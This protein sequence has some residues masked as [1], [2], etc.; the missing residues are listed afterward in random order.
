MIDIT[1]FTPL[2]LNE[3]NVEQIF[4]DCLTE[5]EQNGLRAFPLADI[6]CWEGISEQFLALN[7]IEVKSRRPWAG[8]Y[9]DPERYKAHWRQ[10]VYMLGQLQPISGSGTVTERDFQILADGSRWT[11][12]QEAVMQLITL[13]GAEETGVIGPMRVCGDI[14]QGIA[15]LIQCLQRCENETQEQKKKT[16]HNYLLLFEAIQTALRKQPASAGVLRRIEPTMAP[17]DL[18]FEGW[19]AKYLEYLRTDALPGPYED[20]P[21][22]CPPSWWSGDSRMAQQYLEMGQA[23]EAKEELKSDAR[24]IEYYLKSNFYFGEEAAGHLDRMILC[25]EDQADALRAAGDRDIQSEDREIRSKGFTELEA[26]AWLGDL[27]AAYFLGREY[28]QQGRADD[29]LKWYEYAAEAFYEDA[30]LRLGKYYLYIDP[31]LEKAKMWL[32]TAVLSDYGGEAARHMFYLQHLG[33][34]AS[35]MSVDDRTVAAVERPASSE[36]MRWLFYAVEQDDFEAATLVAFR[37]TEPGAAIPRENWA[38]RKSAQILADDREHDP[39]VR[40]VGNELLGKI[41]E[42]EKQRSL[43]QPPEPIRRPSFGRRGPA[44]VRVGPGPRTMEPQGLQEAPNSQKEP[45]REK[46]S[47]RGRLFSGRKPGRILA[48]VLT[49]VL[50]LGGIGVGTVLIRKAKDGERIEQ[51][52]AEKKPAGYEPEESFTFLQHLDWNLDEPGTEAARESAQ[53]TT[54]EPAAPAEAP[55]K[56]EAGYSEDP[57]LRKYLD[58]A[59]LHKA[60]AVL[61]YLRS[62]GMEVTFSCA[63]ERGE[64]R[65]TLEL[66]YR[67]ENDSEKYRLRLYTVDKVTLD[68][69]LI[70]TE[71]LDPGPSWDVFCREIPHLEELELPADLIAALDD[72]NIRDDSN[73]SVSDWSV[74]IGNVMD[75]RMHWQLQKKP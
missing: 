74:T 41:R 14:H 59:F 70:T 36:A 73:L 22:G 25:Y 26:A 52:Q 31:D 51:A 1:S 27:E 46:E 47:A 75:V 50:I 44:A 55:E 42:A 72:V 60:Q 37:F 64:D 24:A 49:L 45:F 18:G 12:S 33:E 28:Q 68:S 48:M 71:T 9:F 5:D 17:A 8:A 62:Q 19:Y 29:M 4:T 23:E 21:A 61:D 53:E 30:G 65:G 63:D 32:E 57:I 10:I 40:A 11:G 15:D 56:Y 20:G 54:Q 13:A 58:I 43:R 7:G 67:V 16:Y 39:Q 2:A 6:V 3:E 69:I 34:N 38:I 66:D 35:R